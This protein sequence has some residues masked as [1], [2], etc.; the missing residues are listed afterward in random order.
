[1]HLLLRSL[2]DKGHKRHPS[3]CL[4][5]GEEAGL[6]GARLSLEVSYFLGHLLCEFQFSAESRPAAVLSVKVLPL[7]PSLGRV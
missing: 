1:M 7:T 6:Q 4:L 5:V 3:L 2:L